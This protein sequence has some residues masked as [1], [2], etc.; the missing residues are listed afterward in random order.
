VEPL[1]LKSTYVVILLAQIGIR[2][3]YN[4]Q[5]KRTRVTRNR[6][7]CAESFVL[8]ALF[9]CG[10]V[11]PA[12]YIVTPFLWFANYHLPFP[13]A[14]PGFGF[15]L[16]G[17]V[18]FWRAHA[19]LGRQWS[20]TLQVMEEHALVTAGIYSVVRHPMYA[21]QLLVGL[22]QVFL[23]QNWIAGWTGL[24]A[25]LALYLLRVPPEERMMLAEFGD[26]Y[27]AYMDRTGRVLPRVGPL[28][29]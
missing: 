8:V 15:G 16:A 13:A 24:V 18:V 26:E 19:D 23:L 1:L 10:V 29:L 11:I 7:G 21:S 25:F 5:R 20:P 2:W 3:P 4:R 14:L 12:V 28:A 9:V 22:A 17:L 6:M 27:R